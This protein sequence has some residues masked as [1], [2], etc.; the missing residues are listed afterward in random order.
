MKPERITK[1]FY[2]GLEKGIIYGRRCKECGAIEFPPHYACNTCGYHETEWTE[3]SGD[4]ML[5]SFVLA[6]PMNTRMELKGMGPYC[7]GAV[8]LKEG[9]K[10]NAVVFG[11]SRKNAKEIRKNLPVPVRAKITQMDGYKS[12][13]FEVVENNLD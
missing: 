10:M 12:L 7:F 8:S 1:K 11:V 2:D 9:G 13:F 6:G 3:M 5:E 4:G